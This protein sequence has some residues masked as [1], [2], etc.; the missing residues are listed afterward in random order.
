MYKGYRLT[1]RK[2]N[3]VLYGVLASKDGKKVMVS[4]GNQQYIGVGRSRMA[5]IQDA[6]KSINMGVK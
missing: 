6:K 3:S 1:V 4:S 2:M 5:A